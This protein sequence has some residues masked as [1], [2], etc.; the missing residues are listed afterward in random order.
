MDI[1]SLCKEHG[2][3]KIHIKQR[4][5][6]SEMAFDIILTLHNEFKEDNIQCQ[7]MDFILESKENEIIEIKN[8][9]YE[10]ISREYL[11]TLIQK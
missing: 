6:S 1:N 2:W 7:Y 11:E 5:V 4:D 10:K 8:I 9:E 3:I